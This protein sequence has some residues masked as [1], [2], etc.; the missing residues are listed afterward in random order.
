MGDVEELA[1]RSTG[2]VETVCKETR[3]NALDI[4]WHKLPIQMNMTM[5]PI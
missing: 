5:K 2:K 1:M 4:V 3:R